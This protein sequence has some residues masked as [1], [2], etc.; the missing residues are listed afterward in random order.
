MNTQN[1]S[2]LRSWWRVVASF[3][4]VLSILLTSG[5]AIAQGPSYPR[6]AT[7]TVTAPATFDDGTAILSTDGLT[8]DVTCTRNDGTVVLDR[9]PFDAVLPGAEVTTTFVDAIPN[10]GTY[11]CNAFAEVDSVRSDPSNDG[12]KRYTG[13]P[14][15]PVI[16]VFAE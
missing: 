7:L 4:A 11:T 8:L 16:I 6:D 13:Q 3:A 5:A 9:A 10:S 2:A 15:P 1:Q 12:V 14:G